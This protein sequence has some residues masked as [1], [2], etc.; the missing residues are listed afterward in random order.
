M[1]ALWSVT[2]CVRPTT[3]SRVLRLEVA[4]LDGSIAAIVV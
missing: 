4:P 2:G 1:S 3:A